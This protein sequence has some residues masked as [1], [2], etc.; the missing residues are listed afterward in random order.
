MRDFMIGYPDAMRWLN[1]EAFV[2]KPRPPE[3]KKETPS[4]RRARK[5]EDKWMTADYYYTPER[6]KQYA[7]K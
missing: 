2:T 5:A 1:P 6:M 4:E 3:P 7:P